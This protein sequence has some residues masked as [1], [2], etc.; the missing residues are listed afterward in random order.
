ML[1]AKCGV[2][3]GFDKATKNGLDIVSHLPSS[4]TKAYILGK[5]L[6]LKYKNKT[7]FHIVDDSCHLQYYL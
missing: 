3:D 6:E 2:K 4:F 1:A 5:K 7:S